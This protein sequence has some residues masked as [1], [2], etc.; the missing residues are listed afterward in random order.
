MTTYE[1]R[2]TQTYIEF[3]RIDAPNK[4]TA[5]KQITQT[6]TGDRVTYGR[7]V[8]TIKR[9]PQVDYA[10]EVSKEGEVIL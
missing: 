7:K 6:L 10:L 8:D 4:E 5:I 9:Q 2:V 3:F 1:V